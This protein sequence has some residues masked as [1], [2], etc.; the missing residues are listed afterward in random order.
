MILDNFEYFTPHN[1]VEAS[2]LLIKYGLNSR[3]LAGG[4]DLVAK[5]QK[6]REK[7]SHVIDLKNIQPTLKYITFN[8]EQQS[9]NIGALTTF[10]DLS[11][12]DLIK[13]KAP[14]LYQAANVVGSRQ[15]RSRATIGGNICSAAP[16]ADSPP[17]LLVLDAKLVLS[18]MS[19]ERTVDLDKFF[20]SPGKTILKEGEILKEIIL[21]LPNDVTSR[22]CYFKHTRRRALDIAQVGVAVNIMINNKRIINCR[23]ALA[24]AAPT[25]IR[26]YAV[27]ERL[28]GKNLPLSEEEIIA[29]S[30]IVKNCASPRTSRRASAEYR[31]DIIG[32][33][34]IKAI[35]ECLLSYDIGGA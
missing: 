30:S 8:D 3:I 12:S 2:R 34:T 4:T 10:N 15:I 22:M 29:V 20:L 19:E 1:L 11:L 17:A 31:T 7:P 23:I 5:M 32:Y 35:R 28:Q 9:L 6:E 33:L 13:N 26:A 27:E 16:S 24:T 14:V 25:P 21:R 18:K